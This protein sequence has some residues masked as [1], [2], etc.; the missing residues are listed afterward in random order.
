MKRSILYLFAILFAIPVTS[1]DVITRNCRPRLAEIDMSKHVARRAGILTETKGNTSGLEAENPL[2]GDRHQL[3]VMAEFADQAFKDDSI[4]TLQ[5]WDKILNS[6]NF[7]DSMIAGSMHDYFYDQSYG[8]L[9]LSFDL[10]YVVVE[11]KKKYRS[12]YA[13][14]E[15]SK[16]LVQDVVSIIK[17]RVKDWGLYDWDNDGDVDQLL[18]IYAGKGQNDGGG[19]MTIWPHQWWMSE[20]KDCQPVSVTSGSKTYRVNS[21]CTVQELSGKGDYGIFGTLCHEY[22]HCFGL[23]DFYDGYNQYVSAWD[24]MD[25]G[26]YNGNGFH[27][28]GYSSFERAFMGWL[29]PVELKNDTVIDGMKALSDAPVSYLIRN[30]GNA[31]EYYLVEN[32]QMTGWDETLPG[33]GIVVF[34]VDYDEDT[35]HKG[36]VNSSTKKRYTI[37]PANDT[38]KTTETALKGWAYPYKS[39]NGLTNTSKPA[40]QLNNPNIDGSLLMSKP[41][42]DMAVV[43][44][45]ASFSFMKQTMAAVPYVQERSISNNDGWFTTDGRRLPDKP[46]VHG[47]YIHHGKVVLVR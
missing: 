34:H 14:D 35:F 13:D 25:Y 9:N 32:R 6:R 47:L 41:L 24:L 16:Y 23:P 44:C 5:K 18:I 29:T 37:I 30:E 11:N 39:N 42:T 33:S 7:K 27:P 10:L 40:A 21:Y 38:I 36:T 22:S 45:L 15:N 17:N 1:Q 12:T 2:I 28:C 43:N 26:N 19:S 8:Q 31:N 3:V 46:A 4:L 20:H